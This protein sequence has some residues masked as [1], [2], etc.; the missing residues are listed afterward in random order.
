LHEH[1]SGNVDTLE[2]FAEV[3]FIRAGAR[4]RYYDFCHRERLGLVPSSLCHNPPEWDRLIQTQMNLRQVMVSEPR[5]SS[6]NLRFVARSISYLKVGFDA[7]LRI[8]APALP[9]VMLLTEPATKGVYSSNS[10]EWGS[11]FR[12]RF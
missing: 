3:T 9:V 1:P 4:L 5:V 12:T 11:A 8:S 10:A 2:V 6:E 7:G